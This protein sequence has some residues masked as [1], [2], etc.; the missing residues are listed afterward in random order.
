MAGIG[1]TAFAIHWAHRVAKRFQDGQLYI[2]LRGFGPSDPAAP[3]ADALRTLLYSLGIPA[4]DIPDGLDARA[5]HQ[6]RFQ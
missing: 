1:K 4:R 5:G 2:D 3:P 6:P